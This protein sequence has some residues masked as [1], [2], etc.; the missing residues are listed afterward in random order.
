MAAPGENVAART[1][2]LAAYAAR[3]NAPAQAPRLGWLEEPNLSAEKLWELWE[4]VQ[5]RHT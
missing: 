5:V 1:A 2:F 3:A 4:V